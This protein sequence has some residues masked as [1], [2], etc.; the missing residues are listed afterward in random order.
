VEKDI[1]DM[2]QERKAWK[3]ERLWYGRGVKYSAI[4][5]LRLGTSRS[6]RRLDGKNS[7]NIWPMHL[8]DVDRAGLERT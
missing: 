6:F 3:G 5:I 1:P 7:V 2:S 4:Y 8:D